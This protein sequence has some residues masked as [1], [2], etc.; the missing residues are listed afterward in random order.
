M[1]LNRK[2]GMQMVTDSVGHWMLKHYCV[3]YR[4]RVWSIVFWPQTGNSLSISGRR[5]WP[6]VV[7][8]SVSRLICTSLL[9]TLVWARRIDLLYLFTHEGLLWYLPEMSI[10]TWAPLSLV[11]IG[12]ALYT[13]LS[14]ISEI[15]WHLIMNKEIKCILNQCHF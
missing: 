12:N 5:M 7:M 2:L 14:S 13:W 9:F 6:E 10:N 11:C 15:D 3:P 4:H 8:L 1:I